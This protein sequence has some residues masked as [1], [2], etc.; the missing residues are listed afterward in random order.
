MIHFQQLISII[1]LFTKEA[2]LKYLT[3]L[4][5]ESVE[6]IEFEQFL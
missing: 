6:Q 2:N 1:I 3:F 5:A 4:T